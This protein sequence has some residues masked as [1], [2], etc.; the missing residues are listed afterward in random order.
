M[1]S[2]EI[3]RQTDHTDHHI[4]IDEGRGELYVSRFLKEK[5]EAAA[6]KGILFYPGNAFF[7]G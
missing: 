4:W 1:I 5:L 3:L 2:H 6:Y 7:V